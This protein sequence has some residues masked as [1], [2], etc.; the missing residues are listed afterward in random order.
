[1]NEAVKGIESV[2]TQSTAIKQDMDAL[3]K[4]AEN[5]GQIMGVIADI[6]DQ[7]NLLALNAAIEAARAGDAGRGFAVVADEVRKL[8]EKTMTAT[9]EVG[10]AITGIQQGTKK[11]IHNVE[12]VAASIEVATSLS[13][14]SG[15]SLKQ[16]LEFVH[17]VNDQVQ[18]IATA[19]EQQSAASEEINHSVEQVANISAETA[20]AMEQAASAVTELAQQSQAL[21]RLITEMKSQG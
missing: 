19:S 5:I 3:G 6:A 12:Q 8:A 4:Q 10:Q 16:I 7:T 20:Q 13:V 15:E 9:Q 21:Q 17:M 14:R 11:N 18:S 1:M 2:H